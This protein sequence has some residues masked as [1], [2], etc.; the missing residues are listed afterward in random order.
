MTR[1]ALAGGLPSRRRGMPP[2]R[3]ALWMRR[4]SSVTCQPPACWHVLWRHGNVNLCYHMRGGCSAVFLL[5]D[6]LK[7]F[8]ELS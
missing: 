5:I 3:P 7:L 8:I 2:L 6:L 1:A 4:S